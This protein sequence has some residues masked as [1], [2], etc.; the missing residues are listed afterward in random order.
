MGFW[1]Q[2]LS[3]AQSPLMNAGAVEIR[4]AQT[5]VWARLSPITSGLRVDSLPDE[6]HT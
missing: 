2:S 4:V 5:L 1:K 3:D 6:G